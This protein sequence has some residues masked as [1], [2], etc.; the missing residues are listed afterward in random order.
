V[1]KSETSEKPFLPEI[2]PL[3]LGE[4]MNSRDETHADLA[5]TVEELAQW[6]SIVESGLSE[7]LVSPAVDVIQEEQEDHGLSQLARGLV[8]VNRDYIAV[9]ESS[10]RVNDLISTPS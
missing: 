9:D 10:E 5:R 3:N 1:K 8:E 7:L 6:L 2:R 4:L